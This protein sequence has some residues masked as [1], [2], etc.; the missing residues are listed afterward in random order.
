M[1]DREASLNSNRM[2][3]GYCYNINTQHTCSD[4]L[5]FNMWTDRKIV[6]SICNVFVRLGYLS[7][8][9]KQ[10]EAIRE[11]VKGKDVFVSP[12]GIEQ[13]AFVL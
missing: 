12:H 10:L 3:L 4:L 8:K 11:F 5:R 13:L 9:S 6:A 7:V 2:K 1:V